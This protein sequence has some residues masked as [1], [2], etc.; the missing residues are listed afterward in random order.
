M[1][2]IVYEKSRINNALDVGVLGIFSS[3]AQAKSAIMLKRIRLSSMF[4]VNED[5]VYNNEILKPFYFHGK[6][7]EKVSWWIDKQL[8]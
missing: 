5:S 2:F 1:K 7:G 3:W 8:D 4:G 6:K